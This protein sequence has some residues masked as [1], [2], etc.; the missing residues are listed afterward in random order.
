MILATKGQIRKF[1]LV[2]IPMLN[3]A[4]TLGSTITFRAVVDAWP[5]PQFRWIKEYQ[6][7]T[8]GTVSKVLDEADGRISMMEVFM[9]SPKDAKE[10]S[11][12]IL[13]LQLSDSGN[14]SLEVTADT[15]VQ[16]RTIPLFVKS[17]TS[18]SLSGTLT[19]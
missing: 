6:T 16:K 9:S 12:K 4:A 1:E 11:I 18:D 15:V 10:K 3:G 5:D 19:P 2:T 13:D 14:Y 17:M 8:N 7:V